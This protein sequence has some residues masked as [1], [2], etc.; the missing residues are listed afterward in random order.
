M[1]RLFKLALVVSMVVGL[2]M[3]S[4]AAAS[5]YTTKGTTFYP[6]TVTELTNGDLR[7]ELPVGTYAAGTYEL[8]AHFG[9]I[10][11]TQISL[12][13]DTTEKWYLL[14]TIELTAAQASTLK[15]RTIFV[16]VKPNFYVGVSN[17]Q[18]AVGKGNYVKYTSGSSTSSGS[19]VTGKGPTNAQ[20]SDYSNFSMDVYA[21]SRVTS[22]KASGS[23]VIVAGYMFEN[24]SNNANYNTTKNWREI[25]FVN[26]SNTSSA[27]AYRKLVT[28][29]YNTWLNKN[30]TATQNGKYSLNYANYTVT[31]NPSAVYKYSDGKNTTPVKMASGTYYVYMRI[32]NGSTTYLFPLR[33]ATLSDGTNMENTGT[34]PNGFSVY[35]ST[36]RA[37]TYTVK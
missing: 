16:D 37:L 32:S 28:P 7:V 15:S 17:I 6:E 34:L 14:G 29:V 18:I 5:S 1:K 27:Y 9:M 8:G 12:T 20:L 31:V 25:I 30:A 23:S 33:D 24:G 26:A 10:L 2:C 3:S 13:A 11:D 19:V 4:V 36:T 22:I 35:D 21:N